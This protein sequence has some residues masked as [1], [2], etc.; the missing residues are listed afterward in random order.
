MR[1][2]KV[3]QSAFR[4][5]WDEILGAESHVRTLRVLDQVREPMSVREVSRRARVQLRSVQVA[6]RKLAAMGLVEFV[7]SGPRQQIRLRQEHPLVQP[8]R[9]L[10]EAERQRVDR[11]LGTLR[12]VAHTV[13]QAQAI[14]IEGPVAEG[15]DTNES[16]ITVG[17]LSRSGE[18]DRLVDQ[19]RA[20]LAEVMHREDLTIDVQGWTRADLDLVKEEHSAALQQAI[21]LLGALPD[22]P[23]STKPVR[24]GPRSHVQADAE[25]LRKAQRVAA[26]LGR[27]P[28]L[29]RLAREEVDR[30]LIAAPAQEARTLREWKQ[31][32]DGLS[33]LRLRQWLVDPGQRATRLRQ[34]MPLTFL[35]AAG[36]P[37]DET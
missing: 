32:L 30:S 11:I 23:S 7:G 8:I 13:P 37:A 15:V 31:Q 17:L 22:G 2:M 19:L 16:F 14:W 25:L 36:S 5:P 10:Y 24:S 27:N 33:L 3:R 29:V 21:L 20:A 1:T 6:I 26:A 9:A 28:E 18:I 12:Q 35:R 4:T 34:S